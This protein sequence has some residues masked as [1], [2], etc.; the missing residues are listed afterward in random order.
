M[1]ATKTAGI[2]MKS[3]YYIS[4]EDF[5]KM[6]DSTNRRPI[7]H[8]VKKDEIRVE[9]IPKRKI[10]KVIHTSVVVSNRKNNYISPEEFF[11]I[12]DGKELLKKNEQ[13]QTPKTTSAFNYIPFD[14]TT[15]HS[16]ETV[17]TSKNIPDTEVQNVPKKVKSGL[18][19][20]MKNKRKIAKISKQIEIKE[21]RYTESKKRNLLSRILLQERLAKDYFD[22]VEY[23]YDYI[24]SSEIEKSKNAIKRRDRKLYKEV[25]AYEDAVED[26]TVRRG[27]TTFKIGL[28]TALLA[29]TLAL[30]HHTGTEV[31]KSFNDMNSAN[32]IVSIY[33]MNDEEKEQIYLNAIQIKSDVVQR[34]GYHFDNLSEAEFADGYIRMMK[35]EKKMNKQVFEGAF[36]SSTQNKDQD[37]LDKIVSR[38]FEEDYAN[39]TDA[40]KRDYRQLAYELLPYSLPQHFKDGMYYVRNPLVIDALNARNSAKSKGYQIELRFNSDEKENL[41]NFGNI[42]HILNTM[43]EDRYSS[44]G[45]TEEEQRAFFTGIIDE[46]MGENASKLSK[47]QRKDYNQMIYELLSSDAK[48]HIVDPLEYEKDMFGRGIGE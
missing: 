7:Q 40:Q 38:A 20:K 14:K 46:V 4:P 43:P 33:E 15:T 37:L 45:Q 27:W 1:F 35:V 12:V 42:E 21:N 6:I 26:V 23:E 25:Q 28:A 29:G 10:T 19:Q 3:S 48:Q 18:L 16:K 11:K 32:Q 9:E 47:T 8:I 31:A 41:R 24:I 2:A 30:A 44:I 17:T 39:F 5:F 34:D 36:L 13:V 22:N